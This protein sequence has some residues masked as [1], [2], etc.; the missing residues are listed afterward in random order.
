MASLGRSL[1]FDVWE[2]VFLDRAYYADG[3]MV[4]RSLPEALLEDDESIRRRVRNL[5][6]LSAVDAI[7]GSLI[8]VPFQTICVHS[9]TKD[10]LSHL[11]LLHQSLMH[12]RTR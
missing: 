12:G 6:E 8:E 7:D 4:S 9:D 1:G 3:R 10:A 11:Q 5:C 2:E